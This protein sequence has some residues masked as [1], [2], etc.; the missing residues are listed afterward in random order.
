MRRA[1]ASRPRV[2]YPF[3]GCFSSPRMEQGRCT[4]CRWHGTECSWTRISEADWR[5]VYKARE[6]VSGVASRS[7]GFGTF[8]EYRCS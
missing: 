1:S 3:E 4:N 2:T 6:D 5:W 8:R 7:I